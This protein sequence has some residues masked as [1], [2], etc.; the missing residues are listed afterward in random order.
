MLS[1]DEKPR[2]VTIKLS[3][4]YRYLVI[5]NDT[6]R[7]LNAESGF[8]FMLADAMLFCTINELDAR[9]QL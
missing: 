3:A 8:N 4:D 1:T 7:I 9:I 5:D 2:T 6:H